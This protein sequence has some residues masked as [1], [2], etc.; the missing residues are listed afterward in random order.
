MIEHRIELWP[1]GTRYLEE[2]GPGDPVLF[3]HGNPTCA[4]DWLPFF[5]ALKDLRRCMAPDLL[6]WGA[7]DRVAGA[8]HSMDALADWL[9]RL[10]EELE[11]ER[12]DLV[13]HDWGGGVG[14]IAAQLVP[15]RVGRVV[16]INT[17]PLSAAHRWH[18]VA[19]IWRRRLLGE[20]FN[21][22]T[23]RKA[24]ELTLRQATPRHGSPPGVADLTWKYLDRGTKRAILQLYR[25]ADPDLLGQRGQ[26]LT[27]LTGP[28]LVVWGDADPYLPARFGDALADQLRGAVEHY[29]DAGHWPWLDRPEIVER[30]AGFLTGAATDTSC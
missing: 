20:L 9:R 1:G 22:I 13:T 6:G 30:V 10:V 5:S 15:E 8:D 12:F 4:D 21:A 7:S 26:G 3:V 25:S 28:G 27:R 11:L 23:S 29:A 14:L 24:L 18:W 2:E 19:Q 17:V 16:C